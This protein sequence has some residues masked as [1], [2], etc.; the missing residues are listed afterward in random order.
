MLYC[1]CVVNPPGDPLP[2]AAFSVVPVKL[3]PVPSV[4]SST[5]P[6][7]ED[8]RP[9]SFA[10]VEVSP[11]PVASPILAYRAFSA[12]LTCAQVVYFDTPASST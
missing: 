8:A 1:T 10:V 2:P 11:E 9:S 5:A 7:P 12:V 3:S 4:I 6:V